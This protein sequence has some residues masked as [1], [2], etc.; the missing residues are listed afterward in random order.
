A[1]ITEYINTVNNLLSHDTSILILPFIEN[2]NKSNTR[3][4]IFII[5]PERGIELFKK[6]NEFNIG[7]FLLDEAQISE[8]GIRGMKF[9]SFIRRIDKYLPNA[10]K[11]FAHPFVN[12][13]EAQLLKHNF[14]TN[15]SAITYEQHTVGKI[16]ISLDKEKLSYFSPYQKKI[17]NLYAV[18]LDIVVDVLNNNGSVLI[19]VSKEKIYKE[20][21]ITDFAKYIDMCD[22]LT[23]PNAIKLI[24]KL[25]KFIG[26]SSSGKDKFSALIYMMEKGIVLHHGSM[27]LN[28]RLIM[29]DFVRLKFARI[30]FSTATLIQGINMPFDIVWIDNF[31]NLKTLNLKNLIGRAG[32]TT[33][34]SDKFEFGYV[35]VKKQNIATFSKRL[36]ENYNLTETSIIDGDESSIADNDFKDIIEAVKDD[37]FNDDL[38]LTN[39][40]VERLKDKNIKKDIEYIL[41]TMII[42]NKPIPA[43]AYTDLTKHFK[44]KISNSF[45]NIFITHLR[46]ESLNDGET[47]VLHSAIPIMLWKIQGKSFSEI[48]SLRYAYLSKKDEKNSILSKV[49]TNEITA[50]DAEKAIQEISVHF[51]PIPNPLPD[52]SLRNI[53]RFAGVSIDKINYDLLVYDTY[54]YLDKV[55]SLSLADPICGAFQLYYDDTK[56]ERALMMKNYIRYGT[57][58]TTEIWLLRYGFEFEDIEWLLE[59]VDNINEDN[60]TFNNK[61]YDLEEDKFNIIQRY[62]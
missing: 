55:I 29:E 61:V 38:H 17:E 62:I 10:K 56:D 36:Q 14:K 25:R 52:N 5:T 20:K 31:H 19:Y 16:F 26:A 57:N 60:I 48:L 37:T 53:N 23:N 7:L 43:K 44:K 39:T 1:L 4:R 13:P 59:Y 8:E 45:K 2:I 22:K 49:Y 47:G 28:A 40:Q 41:S 30:C 34:S 42:D 11:V 12:N 18:N 50:K 24:E 51:S 9:D 35:I 32:R 46:K 6:I 21:Y 3:R 27:P 58:N 15:S 33:S 54:D